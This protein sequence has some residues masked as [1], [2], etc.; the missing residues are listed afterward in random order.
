MD[1]VFAAPSEYVQGRGA[2]ER[3][4]D[5][6]R[7]LGERAVI[8]SDDSVEAVVGPTVR[9]SFETVD[10]TVDWIRFGGECTRGAVE[11]AGERARAVDAD[12]VVGAGG[13]KAID[14]AKAVAGDLDA[15]MLSVPT[16]AATDA[17]TSSLSI[18]YTESGAVDRA[19][20]GS[21]PDVVLVDTAVIAAAPTKWFVSGIGDALAT[22]YEAQRVRERGAETP[23]GTRPTYTG[24]RL[25]TA[26]TELLRE[27]AAP[28]VR[29][30]EADAVTE[31]VE[32][33]VEAT[34]LLSGLGFE[35]GG[36]A[37]AHGI[38]D[39]LARAG[40]AG[41]HGERVCVGLVAAMVLDGRPTAEL[42]DVAAFADRIGLPRSV[43]ELGVADDRTL[44]TVAEAAC[45]EESPIQ[46]FE[47][48]P[49][50]VADA[51]RGADA[52]VHSL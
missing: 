29:A 32:A 15:A 3:V 38:H 24:T 7:S 22:G 46:S 18:L 49:T 30:V 2:V 11:S 51:L 43:S 50:D 19:V 47:V 48:S 14:T 35:N 23:L 28:A 8:L 12:V 13:G 21:H 52:F 16:I 42:R 33:T 9:E 5:Y 1:R 31:H 26:C 34:L 25:A 17:P 41:T 36:L 27:H 20:A 37:A 6:C 10:C 39:G 4:G 44:T 40:V 45:H